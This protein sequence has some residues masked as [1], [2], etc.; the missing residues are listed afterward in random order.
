MKKIV[1]SFLAILMASC[2]FCQSYGHLQARHTPDWFSE[3]F[4]YQLVCRNFSEEGTLKGAQKQ[5]ERLAG[6]GCNVIY[7]FPVNE[8]DD[9]MDRSG[10]SPRQI[11]SGMN[12]PKNPYRAK[13]YFHVDPEYGTDRDLK[14]FIDHAHSL[15][16]KVFIDLVF[17]H[18]GPTAQVVRQHP[19]Y[20]KHDK[21]GNMMMTRWHFPMF[22]HNNAG[23]RAYMRSIMTYYVADFN[24]DGFRCDVADEV[25]IDFWEEAR[26]ELDRLNRDLV[27]VAEG[28]NAVN[29]RY[30]FD[31]NYGWEVSKEMGRILRLKDFAKEKGGADYIRRRHALA[32]SR[33][34]EGTLLWQMTEN[35]DWATDDFENRKEKVYG[36]A[37]QELGLAFNFAIDGVPLVFNGQEVCYDKRL[38]MFG[39]EGCWIDWD[40]A[41]APDYAKDRSAR[42]KA[43]AT[44]RREYSSLA[45]GQTIWIDN[46]HP[47]EICSFL[48]HDGVSPDIIFVGNFSETAIKAKLSDGRKV[49]LAPWGYIFEPVK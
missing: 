5:L 41:L 16:M 44:M 22:D 28:R 33:Y 34:P 42:I 47:F 10:W 48:R 2:A 27:I 12:N 26:G 11:K 36:H 43:W 31:A 24:V 23:T 3:G 7:L 25:P 38:S 1:S 21:D 39:H 46:D 13:D 17:C 15:G 19:D 30:A 32:M 18:C 49:S 20:F 14:D 29:T 4:S 40:E 35:H 9:D 45:H 6:L 37:N 8:S